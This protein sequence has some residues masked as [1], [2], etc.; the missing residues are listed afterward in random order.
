MASHLGCFEGF[1]R[2]I[3]RKLLTM[4][5]LPWEFTERESEVVERLPAVPGGV[6]PE[7]GR[8]FGVGFVGGVV[9][10][11]RSD[12]WND[13]VFLCFVCDGVP[14][15]CSRGSGRFKGGGG[16]GQ[17]RPF[18]G[19]QRRACIGIVV[20]ERTTDLYFVLW[21]GSRSTVRNG[22]GLDEILGLY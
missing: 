19:V 13:K 10:R 22:S 2:T 8:G 20:V 12:R 6:R 7:D 16:R 21:K 3:S 4:R 15:T 9:R 11:G 1:T 18:E 17:D 5:R 14:D